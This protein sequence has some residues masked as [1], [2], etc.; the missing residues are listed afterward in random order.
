MK[1]EIKEFEP[2]IDT[3]YKQFHSRLVSNISPDR[4]L[5]IKIPLVRK[6]AAQKV[7][8]N[9]FKQVLKNPN[10]YFI[11]ELELFG[12]IV[13]KLG[14]SFEET[15]SYVEKMLPYVDTWAVCDTMQFNVFKKQPIMLLPCV[16]KWLKSGE[17]YTQRFGLVCLLKYY[18]NQYFNKQIL[19]YSF[20]PQSTDYYV[21]MAQAWF[22]SV[23]ACFHYDE[24]YDLLKSKKLS[25]NVQNFTIKKCCESF[26]LTPFKKEQLKQLKKSS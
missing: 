21:Q 18:S 10:K 26:R 6:V 25:A 23:V 7:K 20:L 3:K 14:L 19:K 4:I 5:G 17:V 24:I 16:E 12:M 13:D 22:Y 2:L 1:T 8:N 9:T 11:E 15:V